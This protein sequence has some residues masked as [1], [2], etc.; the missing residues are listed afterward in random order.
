MM[1][2]LDRTVSCLEGDELDVV[3]VNRRTE[4]KCGF[5]LPEKVASAESAA[6]LRTEM[7][8]GRN[9]G[10]SVTT[11]GRSISASRPIMMHKMVE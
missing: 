1:S 3:A 6:R 10:R 9:S 11:A 5:E 7:S 2:V 8:L 4:S